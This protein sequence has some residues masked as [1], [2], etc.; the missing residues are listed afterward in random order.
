MTYV[1]AK[2]IIA[3]IKLVISYAPFVFLE[4]LI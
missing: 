4:N 2:S 1:I 3:I